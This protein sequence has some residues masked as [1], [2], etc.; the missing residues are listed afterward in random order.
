MGLRVN[1]NTQSLAA[2]RNLGINNMAQ[3]SSIEKLASGSRINH[4]ADDAAGLAI[5]E[6]M[7]A[8]IRS[9]RQDMR[10][11]NDGISMIQT[12]E[13]AMT[14]VSNILIRFREL[15]VQAASDT[16]GDTERG[17]IDKEVQQLK[18]EINRIANAT[19]F[20]GHK[21]LNGEGGSMDIQIGLNNSPELDRFVYDVNKTNVTLDH[22]GLDGV[23]VADKGSAQNNLTYIDE[24]IKSLSGNRAELGALQNRLQSSVNSMGIYDE[25][26]SA[27]RSRIWDV[28]MASETAEL[29]KE[30]I[31]SQAGISVL[32]QANQ[33]NQLAL[34]LLG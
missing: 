11:A 2:Q 25:N 16:I 7:R 17:F 34:K 5:S 22:L 14:E 13:G 12:A 18:Q 30:N 32:G 1:T 10:N 29:T 27:A 24:A 31:L 8:S 23:S 3:K 28:D 9:V 6:K 15:S 21:L 33:N 19:E 4:A 26:M 20:N